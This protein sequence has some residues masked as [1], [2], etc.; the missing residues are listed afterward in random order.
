MKIDTAN[1]KEFNVSRTNE[2]PG[3]LYIEQCKCGCAGD[4]IDGS[5]ICYIGA[6]KNDNG[7]M[8]RVRLDEGLISHG[9]G[10]MIICD[11]QGSVG[12]SNYMRDDFIG[13]TTTSIGYDEEINQIRAMFIVTCLD[14]DRYKYSYGRKYRPS[15]NSAVIKL[16]VQRNSDGII[17]K[18]KSKKYSKEGYIPDWQ[19]MEQYI[20]SL[21]HKP[22]T[23]KNRHAKVA[24]LNTAQWKEFRF[25]S[26]I[27]DVYKSK[28][29]NKEDIQECKKGEREIRY[30]TRTGEDNGCELIASMYGIDENYIEPGNALT[31][32]DTTATC[33]YQ[34]DPFFTGEHIVV[35]RADWLNKFNA[36]YITTI[37]GLEIYKYSYGRAFLIDRIKDTIIKLPIIQTPKGEAYIDKTHQYSKKGY[38][39]DWQFME[40][41]IKSLPY[42]DRL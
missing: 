16:P 37:L 17:I 26:L 13:S 38:I 23:T 22:L 33:F 42:G 7:V 10:I 12:Y 1:W 19:F 24:E 25:G 2:Q 31:I 11:G 20:K 15:M 6:K 9:N 21:H 28:S 40:D 29:I 8:K 27:K 3:L 5:E 4:L 14:L 34:K 39:P 30:I 32:G 36:M 41:Y 35:V 18:D